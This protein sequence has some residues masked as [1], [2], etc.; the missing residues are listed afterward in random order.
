MTEAR[1]NEL[2]LAGVLVT[3]PKCQG[4]GE[5]NTS[6]AAIHYGRSFSCPKCGGVGLLKKKAS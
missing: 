1:K 6:K 5:E 2:I 3:C 4:T